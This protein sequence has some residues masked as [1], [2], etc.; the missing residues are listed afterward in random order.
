MNFNSFR[1]IAATSADRVVT[2]SKG[3]SFIKPADVIAPR[4]MLIED[5]A[6]EYS[7]AYTYPN[8]S[9][10]GKKVPSPLAKKK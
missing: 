5:V 6:V 1:K 7:G 2:E 4:I 10:K 8:R 9:K 3:G